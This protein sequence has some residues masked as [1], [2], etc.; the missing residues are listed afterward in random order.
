M[1]EGNRLVNK[2]QTIPWLEIEKL[3][4]AL[5]TNRRGNNVTTSFFRCFHHSGK[6]GYSNE[7]TILQIQENSYLE[8]LQNGNGKYCEYSGRIEHLDR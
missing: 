5:F 2:A 1:K 4:I 7:E 3:Y 6:Y 8:Y